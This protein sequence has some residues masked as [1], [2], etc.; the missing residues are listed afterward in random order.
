M[1]TSFLS[2]KPDSGLG[3]ISASPGDPSRNID[4]VLMSTQVA[5][6]VIGFFVV[7]SA[8]RTRIAADP[9]AFVT[10]QVVFAIMAVR[11]DVDRDVVRLRVVEGAR[12][13]PLR[14][15]AGV[16]RAAVPAR[17]RGRR[18]QDLLRLRAVQLPARRD[19]EVHH[20]ADAGVVPGRGAQRG[21][22]VRPVPRR[23]DDRRRPGGA[24]DHPARPRVGLGHRVGGDGRAARRRREGE[25][26]RADHVPV[27]GHGAGRVRRAAGQRLPVGA[28]P[29]VV[30]PGCGGQRRDLPGGERHAGHRHRAEC[31]ARVGCRGR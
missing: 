27:G 5:L 9:Y 30:Q 24:R 4:W 25:V 26:H 11:R 23:T 22:V 12:R 8:S 21:G 6:T 10:R 1:A 20:A 3:N 14:P 7:Y 2:R 15:D 29:G 31:G 28:H 19:G 16:P 17:H 18:G 13:L